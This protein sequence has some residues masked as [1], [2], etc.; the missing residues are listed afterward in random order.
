MSVDS[1][2]ANWFPCPGGSPP[3]AEHKKAGGRDTVGFS[4]RLPAQVSGAV[5]N[6]TLPWVDSC[7]S[8]S[9]PRN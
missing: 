1:C 6:L 9:F 5:A 3:C 8:N 7:A 4:L 2:A